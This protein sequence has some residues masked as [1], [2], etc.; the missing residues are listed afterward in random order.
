MTVDEDATLPIAGVRV[1][2]SDFN[3]TPGGMMEVTIITSHGMLTVS[4]AAGILLSRNDQKVTLSGTLSQ[5]NQALQ[6][7]TYQG[8]ENWYG[9]DFLTIE[10][11]DRGFTGAGGALTDSQTIPIHV[12]A[13]N[14]APSWA[15]PAEPLRVH[16]DKQLSIFGVKVHDVDAEQLKQQNAQ[17]ITVVDDE[18]LS[19]EV[20][21]KFGQLMLRDTSGLRFLLPNAADESNRHDQPDGAT[22]PAMANDRAEMY[23]PVTGDNQFGTGASSGAPPQVF[24]SRL[25]FT[26]TQSS[27]NRALD[28]MVYM[29]AL[30]WNS[31]R[32]GLDEL[33]FTVHDGEVSDKF[34]RKAAISVHVHAVNDAPTVVVK[35]LNQHDNSEVNVIAL[36][37]REDI[38]LAIAGVSIVDVDLADDLESNTIQV[39]IVAKHGTVSLL[40]DGKLPSNVVIVAGNEHGSSAITF[41]ATLLSANE[42]L[43]H[44][45]FQGT[46]DYHGDADIT[47][48]VN[49]LGNDGA[50]GALGASQ[51]IAIVIHAENDAPVVTVPMDHELVRTHVV[52]EGG[53]VTIAGARYSGIA[54]RTVREEQQIGFE[55]WRSEGAR[56]GLDADSTPTL[57]TDQNWG[58]GDVAWRHSL[59][60][61]IAP[62]AKASSPRHF[63]VLGDLLYF[64]AD[65]ATHGTELWRTDGTQNGTAIVKDLQPGSHGS[66]PR[67][68]TAFGGKLYFQADGVDTTWMLQNPEKH[69]GKH[70]HPSDVDSCNGFRQSSYNPDVHYAVSESN[71]WEKDKIYDCPAGFHWASTAE[72]MD[73]FSGTHGSDAASASD[74]MSYW[75]Q[76]GW[77]DFEWG[78]KV[79]KRFRFVDSKQTGAYKHSG[80]RDSYTPEIDSGTSDFAGIVCVRGDGDCRGTM[81]TWGLGP[82]H[83]AAESVIKDRDA[84]FLRSGSELWESDGTEHGTKRVTDNIRPGLHGSSPSFLTEMTVS[85]TPQLFFAAVS[86][87]HGNELWRTDGTEV[88]T[89]LVDDIHYGHVGSEPQFLTVMNNKLY[90]SANEDTYATEPKLFVSDGVARPDESI[91]GRVGDNAKGTKLVDVTADAWS[92]KYLTACNSKLFFQARNDASGAELFSTNGVFV[93]LVKDIQDGAAGSNP[94][95][96]VCYN[97]EVYFQADDGKHGAEL[98][99]SDGVSTNTVMVDMQLGNFGGFPGSQPSY[100]TVFSATPGKYDDGAA[101]IY[102]VAKNGAVSGGTGWQMWRTDGTTTK[103]AFHQTQ[104]GIAL[105]TAAMSADY[106]PQ[107]AIYKETLYYSANNAH[108]LVSEAFTAGNLDVSFDS[109]FGLSQAVVV[110]DVDGENQVLSVTMNCSKGMFSLHDTADLTFLDG[111]GFLDS[112]VTFYG[113]LDS[114]NQ[115]LTTLIYR[116]R[117]AET[118][119]DVIGIYVFDGDVDDEYGPSHTVSKNIPLKI[120]V[121]NSGVLVK[122]PSS[123]QASM[124]VMGTIP[125]IVV[126]ELDQARFLKVTLSSKYGNIWLKSLKGLHFLQGRGVSARSMKFIG[127]HKHVSDS[128]RGLQYMCSKKNGC[129]SAT[130][131]LS[132]NLVDNANKTQAIDSG[133]TKEITITNA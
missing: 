123:H 58:R 55:L 114:I 77:S 13:V 122:V 2:D 70:F 101:E 20:S 68:L 24:W 50:G 37:A 15:L 65:D 71:V 28:G 117:K 99:K 84:C 93:S 57:L 76:C 64:Q 4:H 47:I 110:E 22:A 46:A 87:E 12:T 8:L 107:L 127:T 94:S 25:A 129:S 113:S 79:R 100:L 11:D 51:T 29:P 44:L 118:G 98:W 32:K 81:K 31:A 116:P 106:P 74:Q 105:D 69:L 83:T 108:S 102:F 72:A 125:G 30:N 62:G 115:A 34:T 133:T 16:E 86:D 88:G 96:M 6:G 120:T 109:A 131:I 3:D 78:G 128:L 132:L 85:G 82:E 48:S 18:V 43:Q 10:A 45:A 75:N 39:S 54:Q 9:E 21:A 92:P 40:V 26:G 5:I 126:D 73:L 23:K 53:L 17:G 38:E 97:N 27:I 121:E 89:V 63:A 112:A 103:R 19:V 42:A 56:P 66:A 61:D 33:Q 36:Q 67:Y 80:R 41:R 119:S 35:G 90:F 104:N 14:D 111:T 49:D 60:K 52:N 91:A 130:D 1:Q 7:L 124:G 59:V 95:Y